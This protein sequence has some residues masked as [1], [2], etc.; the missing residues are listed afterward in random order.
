MCVRRPGV[1]EPGTIHNEAFSHYDL[2]LT[3]RAAAGEPD[4]VAKSPSTVD[5]LLN[6]G[7]CRLLL[8]LT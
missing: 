6:S 4:I 3:F 8:A 5:T 1:I 2:I 7:P